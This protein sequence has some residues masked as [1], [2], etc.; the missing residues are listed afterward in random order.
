M[1]T[2]Q[3]TGDTFERLNKAL[4][5]LKNGVPKVVTRGIN[6]ALDKGRTE[7]WRA[8]KAEYLIKQTPFYASLSIRRASYGSLQGQIESRAT[9]LPVTLFEVK[10]PGY[11]QRRKKKRPI[12]IRVKRG[13]GGTV[14]EGFLAATG[15]I[16]HGG[17]ERLQPHR[18]PLSE[19]FTIGPASMIGADKVKDE[20][21]R[22]MQLALDGEIDRQAN[23]LLSQT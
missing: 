8:V 18:V 2:I 10:P 19:L 23:L 12:T 20:I 17:F 6:H 13:G 11:Q 14:S 7:S 4:G 1:I 22:A 5:N 21:E 3:I 16:G 15:S 9:N